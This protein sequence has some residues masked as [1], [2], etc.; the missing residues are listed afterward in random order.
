[1][2]IKEI[3]ASVWCWGRAGCCDWRGH[4]VDR[5]GRCL[6]QPHLIYPS[7]EGP[8]WLLSRPAG[9]I[10]PTW[11]PG[12]ITTSSGKPAYLRVDFTM[13]L[14]GIVRQAQKAL[15]L[16][17]LGA[18]WLNHYCCITTAAIT[19]KSTSFRKCINSYMVAD[20]FRKF[21]LPHDSDCKFV[22]HMAA[23]YPGFLEYPQS[24]IPCAL[25]SWMVLVRAWCLPWGG[26]R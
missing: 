6:L 9:H 4:N 23:I 26:N 25:T 21:R 1:M 5:V 8:P 16:Q 24:Q 17:H 13:D 14:S 12:S 10:G 22:W 7:L 19:R 18:F 20:S 2:V 15:G 3:P 11:N